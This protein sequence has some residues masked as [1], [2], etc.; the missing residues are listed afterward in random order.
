M[1]IEYYT[2]IHLNQP[3]RYVKDNLKRMWLMKLTQHSTIT[4]QDFL[5]LTNLGIRL[6]EV[7][8]PEEAKL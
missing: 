6:K 3:R 4:S 7:K 1:I 2:I 8:K 5:A